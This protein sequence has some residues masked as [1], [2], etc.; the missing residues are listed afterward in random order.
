MQLVVIGG[1]TAGWMTAAALS[2]R[3]A[4]S[5]Y[6]IVLIESDAIGTVGVGE[7]T[8]P[9]IREFN[10]LIGVD[11]ADFIRACHATFKL[12]IEFVG[13]GDGDSRYMHPFGRFGQTIG[14][15]EF[16]HSWARARDAGWARPLEEYC[17]AI[18][19]ARQNRFAFPAADG[20]DVRASYD[21]AYHFDA[22]LYA[23]YLRGLAESRG[24][25]RIEGRIVD[26][27]RDAEGGAVRSV[28]LEG[29]RT[30]DGDFFIDCS[31]F[32]SL[33]LGD[34][35][36]AG[37]EDW[38]HWLPCDRAVAVPSDRID[39]LPPYTRSTTRSAGWQWRIPLQRRTGNG[40]VYSSAYIDDDAAVAEL[41]AGL[42]APAQAEPK[43]LR[44][45]AGRRA[46]SWVGNC[47][48]VGL[49][50]GFLEPLEST[51]IHLAQMAIVF[52]LRLLPDSRSVDPTLAAEFN[53]LIDV[54][55]ER[56][57]DFLILH[58]HAA[59]RDDTPLWRDCR[60]MAVPDSLS[61]KIDR[62]RRRG[63][64]HD[65][66]DGLFAPPSWQAVFVGQGIEPAGHDRLADRL[67]ADELRA[68]L[69]GIAREID[70][71]AAGMGDHGAAV[72]AF[73]GGGA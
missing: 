36:Q 32:R 33:L 25:R 18:Q 22:H 46:R 73:C 2:A 31:G 27:V 13:W 23:R 51:S 30:I 34:A 6:D 1:G 63:Y 59:R 48:A 40:Y 70:G 69:E 64:V 54:E 53:R 29:D 7:A 50:S 5:G 10:A 26:V 37:W 62:F 24:V 19:A 41:L 68:Q 72:A 39:P 61:E 8:L 47:V 15:T 56:V 35:M 9:Q 38:S 12:G 58:Y 20:G 4:P 45:R 65:Y 43:L 60:R 52:L 42:D 57:R 3:L 67:G 28:V 71:A 49:A 17:L 14:G 44:F 16:I 11:E 66:R 55:Y 21:Y